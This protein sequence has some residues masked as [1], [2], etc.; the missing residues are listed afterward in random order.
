M[1]QGRK[2]YLSVRNVG[3]HIQRPGHFA[4]D[5]SQAKERTK[6]R[7]FSMTHDQVDPDS[8]IATYESVLGFSVSLPS[9]EEFKSNNVVRNCKIQMQGLDLYAD[10]IVLEMS[11][12]D[13]I[14]GM[15]WLSQH[16]ATI[17]CKQRT[18]SLKVHNGE[19][20]VFYV[21]SKKSTTCFLKRLLGDQEMQ[22][23]KLEEVEVVKDFPEVFP[24]DV[25]GLHPVEEFEFGSSFF[26]ELSQLLRRRTVKKRYP[27]PRID[28]MF[29][30]LQGEVVVFSKIDLL[31]GYHQLRVKDEDVQKTTFKTRYGHYEFLDFSKIAPPLTSLT[32]K[33]VKFVWSEQCAKS[34]EEM[35]ERLMTESVLAIPEG[36]SHFSVYTDASK[37]GLGAVLMQDDKMIAYASRQLKI[38]ERNYPT[39]DFELAAVVFALKLWRH[40]LY[41]EKCK[42][43]IVADALSRNS[44]TLNQLTVQQELIADFEHMSLEVFEPME[45]CT[46]SALTVVPSLLD[47]IRA[48]RDSDKHLLA[49]RN[50]DEAKCGTLYIVKDGIVHHRG[51]MWVPAV[52]SLRVEVMT[53]AHTVPLHGVLVRIVSDRDPKFTSN[54]WGSLHRGLGTKLAFSTVLHPQKDGQSERVIQI[55]E[56]ML[57]AFM[58]DLGGNSES[59]FAFS[60]VYLQQ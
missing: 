24:D 15:D 26:Q 51:R 49:W 30:Q 35:K 13:V 38:H 60:G 2:M 6:G 5:C 34:F 8:A 54:F 7:V 32:Q 57:R 36:T 12:F 37:N 46:L 20:F 9:R 3:N 39:H 19:L 45:V 53:E 16:E 25:A 50:R 47:R 29:D 48:D 18:V 11:D 44:E 43:N 22:R 31:S 55:L 58:I 17:D 1:L 56:Y 59:K 4:K 28:D 27:L 41:G 40:Y 14:F 21:A 42:T 23:P 52:D 10:L 33:G